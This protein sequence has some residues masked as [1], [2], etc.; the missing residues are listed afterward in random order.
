MRQQNVEPK[1]I[2][3]LGLPVPARPATPPAGQGAPD[4]VAELGPASRPT[5]LSK[6]SVDALSTIAATM[7]I[8]ELGRAADVPQPERMHDIARSDT[9]HPSSARVI[10]LR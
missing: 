6:A 4:A 8:A 9:L 10:D 5:S 1:P 3:G 2:P 7:H